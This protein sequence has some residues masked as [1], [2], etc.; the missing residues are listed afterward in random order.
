MNKQWVNGTAPMRVK[1]DGGIILNIPERS[2]VYATG[3]TSGIYV[4]IV[5]RTGQQDITG[6]MY[7]GWLEDYEETLPAN[8]VDIPDQTADPR[9]AE[10][11]FM[12]YGI[13][14]T[15]IC[16]EACVAKL[17]NISV[18]DILERWKQEKPSIW[19]SV[20]GKGKLRGTSSAELISIFEI[21][22]KTSYNLTPIMTDKVIGRPRYT[23]ALLQST[24][25]LGSVIAGVHID[26]AGRL[27]PSGTLHW[28]VVTAVHPERS[29]YGTVEIY[30]PFPNR[31]EIYSWAEF[32]SS[33]RTP[34]GVFVP[35]QAF[36][37]YKFI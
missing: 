24:L 10:Q 21:Y 3:E 33:A 19:R 16:G 22:G 12:M 20:F 26:Y 14:Q 17:L 11:Y 4:E 7:M 8:C 30:N 18:K 1:P 13:K 2:V 27:K 5:Y 28:V 23:P 29:G 35:I 36:Q 6:W 25:D 32:A 15:N 37:K 9:D 31:V 34:A